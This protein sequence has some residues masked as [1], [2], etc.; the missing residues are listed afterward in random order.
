MKKNTKKFQYYDNLINKIQNTRK[1]NNKN[2]MDLLRIGFK[3]KPD[4]KKKIVKKIFFDDKKIN[5]LIKKLV[6]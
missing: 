1:K 3:Y 6:K 2:W 4:E 5:I